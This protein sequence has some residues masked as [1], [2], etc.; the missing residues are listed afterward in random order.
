MGTSQ[1]DEKMY[2]GVCSAG[3]VALGIDRFNTED[4]GD[5]RCIFS[6]PTPFVFPLVWPSLGL[7]DCFKLALPMIARTERR[8]PFTPPRAVAAR[9]RC[10][11][12]QA[13]LHA[14]VFLASAVLRAAKGCA[15]GETLSSIAYCVDPSGIS[16]SGCTGTATYRECCDNVGVGYYSLGGAIGVGTAQPCPG[17]TYGNTG[18]LAT[19]A[20]S[21]TCRCG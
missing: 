14:V 15:A 7:S 10:I 1:N 5:R 6:A 11:G 21:G 20:C 12:S 18:G 19:A 8:L 4:I 3:I 2:L 17:G 16:V 13:S 9:N